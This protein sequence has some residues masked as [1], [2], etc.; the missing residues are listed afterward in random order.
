MAKCNCYF[1]INYVLMENWVFNTITK[2]I[3][4]L[5][6]K[7]LE[8][9]AATVENSFF[10]SLGQQASTHSDLC[11]AVLGPEMDQSLTTLSIYLP[12]NLTFLFSP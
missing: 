1:D 10:P 8:K 2:N 9:E 11:G 4:K 5:C 12:F 7:G 3:H 6:K